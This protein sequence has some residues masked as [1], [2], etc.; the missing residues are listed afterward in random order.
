MRL[1]CLSDDPNLPCFILTVHGRSILLD[2]PLATDHVLDY[3]PVPSPGCLNRFSCL[4]KYSIVSSSKENHLPQQID[5]LRLLHNQL[6]V[7]SPIEFYTFDSSQYD[8]SLVDIILIS[9]YETLLGLPYLYQKYPQLNAQIYMTEPTYRFGQQLMYELVAYVE[10]QSKMIRSHHQWRT[11]ANLFDT[12]ED[13]QKDKKMKLFACAQKLMPCYSI[14][15]VDRCLSHATMV[16][17]NEQI[18]LYSSIRATA[19]SSAY[20]LGTTIES[21][22]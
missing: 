20:A 4:P 10:Q 9:N 3:L 19:L 21:T 18:D 15:D 13:Q 14:A 6:Y 8:I 16:H 12:I 22:C 11:D 2:F 5:E 1:Y 7:Y 17:F